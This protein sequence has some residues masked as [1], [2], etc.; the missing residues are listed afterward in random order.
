M[1][2]EPFMEMVKLYQSVSI[3]RQ[4]VSPGNSDAHFGNGHVIGAFGATR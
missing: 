1:E 2:L 3:L 4:W